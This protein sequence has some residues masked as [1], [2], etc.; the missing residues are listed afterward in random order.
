M[1]P[2]SPNNSQ[3]KGPAKHPAEIQ[4]GRGQIGQS[5][6]DRSDTNAGRDFGRPEMSNLGQVRGRIR[7]AWSKLTDDDMEKFDGNVDGLQSQLQKAYGYTPEKAAQELD[8]FK[9]TYHLS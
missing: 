3:V 9:K 2:T 7:Q 6:M 5:D 1:N 4:G 8:K